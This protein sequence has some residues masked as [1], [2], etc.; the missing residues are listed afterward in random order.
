MGC[1]YEKEVYF[2]GIKKRV[3]VAFFSNWDYFH[4]LVFIQGYSKT[5]P[6]N[7]SMHACRSPPYVRVCGLLA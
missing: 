7:L 2:F 3:K 5:Y 1:S 4:P 6:G